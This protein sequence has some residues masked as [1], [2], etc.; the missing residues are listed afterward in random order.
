VALS[1]LTCSSV[2]D[3]VSGV[4]PVSRARWSSAFGYARENVPI[5]SAAHG[6]SRRRPADAPRVAPA[7]MQ[8][9]ARGASIANA[10]V[11]LAQCPLKYVERRSDVRLS[12]V[13]LL[14]LARTYQRPYARHRRAASTRPDT[15]SKTLLTQR[16]FVPAADG[17]T[18]LRMERLSKMLY[19]LGG[20]RPSAPF[21]L[22]LVALGQWSPRAC[23]FPLPVRSQGC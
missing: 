14:L 21:R 16:G 18:V 23:R 11:D 13:L 20:S 4:A 17:P 15:N 2:S 12:R 6:R 5:R 10:L 1:S 8:R 3:F 22:R 19:R 7:Q 9:K